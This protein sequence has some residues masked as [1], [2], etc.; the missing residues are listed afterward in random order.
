DLEPF[1]VFGAVTTFGGV[2]AAGVGAL[3]ATAQATRAAPHR[4]FAAPAAT[5][6]WAERHRSPPNRSSGADTAARAPRRTPHHAE[7]AGTRT[8]AALRWRGAAPK[9]ARG[10]GAGRRRGIRPHSLVPCGAGRRGTRRPV[11]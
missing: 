4:G 1:A 8:G 3:A 11:D 9:A 7:W 2:T 10:R 6:R 5:L